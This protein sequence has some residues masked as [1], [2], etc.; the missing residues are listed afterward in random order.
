MAS[1]KR[2]QLSVVVPCLNEEGNVAATVEEICALAPELPVDVEVVM[3]DD[4]STDRT[5]EIM[6]SLDERFDRTRMIAFDRNQ[7]AGRAALRAF[8]TIPSDNWVTCFPGDNEMVFESVKNFLE[9]RDRYDLILGYLQNPVIRPIA[10]R[11]ASTLFMQTAKMLYGYDFRY[12]NGIK[13]YRRWVFEGIDVVSSGHAINAEL[14][15]KAI[16]RKPELRIG[17][18]PFAARGRARGTSKAFKPGSVLKAA[19]ETFTGYRSV[20]DYRKKIIRGE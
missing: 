3:V 19:R 20:V 14:M 13:L 8:E 11:A 7:G 15:A 9:V 5:R 10:R 18:A 1:E 6:E 4:G 17:E 16:L 2:E 12:L